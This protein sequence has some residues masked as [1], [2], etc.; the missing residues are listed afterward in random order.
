MAG[1]TLRIVSLNCNGIRA[2]ARKGFYDW[3]RD[4]G[5]DVV[6]LQETK[7]QE[8]QLPL[9]ASAVADYTGVFFN[10]QRRGYSGVAMYV[11]RPPDRIVRGLGWP[12]YDA[13]AR[14]V[15]I[16]YG[17]LS[18]VSFYMPSGSS[19]YVRQKVKEAFMGRFYDEL[20]RLASLGRSFIVAGD[21]NVAHRDIDVYS[22]ARCSHI[23]GFFPHERAWMDRVLTVLGWVVAF[24]V[25]DSAPR[26]YTWWSNFRGDF[27][28]D[29]GWR[30]DYQL[31]TPDLRDCVRAA[32]IARLPRFSDHAAVTIDYEL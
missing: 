26:R 29:R 21:Y 6:C 4:A 25:V 32:S 31:V 5:A 11:K 18:I 14:Y 27:E 2:A 8:H 9:E 13:E 19:G 28:Q 16:D 1:E 24:R 20:A 30:I 10:A 23:S 3:M 22:P 17:T 12:E 15:Q 7:V